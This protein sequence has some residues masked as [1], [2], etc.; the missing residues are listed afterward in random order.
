MYYKLDYIVIVYLDNILIYTKGTRKKHEK[1]TQEVLQLLKKYNIYL[2]KEKS[3]YTKIEVTFLGTI[4][5][6]KELKMEPEKT[7]AVRNW[8]IPKMVKKV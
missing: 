6:R 5:S 1:E 4:I 8:P 2:N 7:K 3:K